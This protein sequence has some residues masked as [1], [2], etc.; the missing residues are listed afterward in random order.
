MIAL[1]LL[2]LLRQKVVSE[3]LVRKLGLVHARFFRSSSN[4]LAIVIL[5]NDGLVRFWKRPETHVAVKAA[6][7][8]RRAFSIVTLLTQRL[9]IFIRV[10][11]SACPRNP[12]VGRELNSW[13]GLTTVRTFVVTLNFERFPEFLCGLSPWFALAGK[14]SRYKLVLRSFFDDAGKSFFALQFPHPAKWITI[15][16]LTCIRPSFVDDGTNFSFAHLRTRN[17]MPFGPKSI[18]DQSV[19]RLKSR[20]WGNEARNSIRQPLFSCLCIRGRRGLGG[21]KQT[22]AGS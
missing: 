5:N 15:G 6:P 17:A 18:E 9:P 14:V 3:D 11:T 7:L 2:L 19:N 21:Q 13:F 12:V 1:L 22:F 4:L 20:T 16:G 10:T 8:A